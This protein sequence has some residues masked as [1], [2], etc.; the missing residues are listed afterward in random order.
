MKTNK[1]FANFKPLFF[2]LGGLALLSFVLMSLTDNKLLPGSEIQVERSIQQSFKYN[3]TYSL[4]VSYEEGMTFQWITNLEEEGTY[5][6]KDQKGKVLASGE[7][8]KSRIHKFSIDKKPGG[9]VNLVFG[10]KDSGTENVT[11]QPKF[12]RHKGLYK[13]VD[14]IYVVGDVHGRYDQM[15]RLLEKSGVVN[16]ELQWS[17]GSAHLIFLGDLFDRGDDVTKVLWFIHELESQ[18]EKKGGKVHL[19]LGNHEIMTMTNDLRYMSRK[20]K[21]ISIAYKVSYDKMFHPT[22]SYLGAWL[23][24]KPSILKIDDLIM[25]HGGIIDLGTPH[26]EEYNDQVYSYMHE[27]M[28]LEILK[29]HADSSAYDPDRWYRMKHFFYSDQAPFWYRGYVNSDTLS[30]Q[31]NTMLNKYNS[32]VHIVAHTTQPTITERYNG[33]V[34]TTDLDDAATQLLFLNRKRNK[35]L[36][37][38][39][40]SEGLQTEL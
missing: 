3:G 16:S 2:S 21:N 38:K 4:Y 5:S 7:T 12:K 39:I 37:Y 11:L 34:L 28:Y 18:A 20:E 26:I 27:D 10:G 24:S 19:V 6:L 9:A 13:K 8:E 23:T 14:S 29:D 30:D 25:A 17:A 40:D 35:Y 1:I 32:K 36:R 22:Q 15:I 33:K 31:L